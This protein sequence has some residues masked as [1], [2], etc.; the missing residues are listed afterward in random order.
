MIKTFFSKKNK[1]KTGSSESDDDLKSTTSHSP[2][3][4]EFEDENEIYSNNMDI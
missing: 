4:L 3:I 2:E 1:N